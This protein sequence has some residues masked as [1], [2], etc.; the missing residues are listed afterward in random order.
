MFTYTAV[1]FVCTVYSTVMSDEFYWVTSVTLP[2]SMLLSYGHMSLTPY[3]QVVEQKNWSNQ[4][5]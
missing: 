3:K 1:Y 5:F 2:R 4:L